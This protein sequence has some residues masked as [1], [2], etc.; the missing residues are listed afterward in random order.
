VPNAGNAFIDIDNNG[1]I[2]TADI[3]YIKPRI[4]NAAPS[5]P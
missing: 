5:C 1:N 2:N 3:T 4:G